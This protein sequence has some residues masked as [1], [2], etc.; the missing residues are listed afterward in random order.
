MFSA[1][2]FTIANTWKQPKCPL[3][4]EQ[5][6]KMWCIYTKKERNNAIWSNMD[7]PKD[8]HTKTEKD[9]YHITYMWNL[10]LKNDTNELTYKTEKD[11]QIL[12]SNLPKEKHAEEG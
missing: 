9:K 12:K 8:S 3:T 2:L 6:K 4:E 5:I 7:G 11:S 10:I 1:A